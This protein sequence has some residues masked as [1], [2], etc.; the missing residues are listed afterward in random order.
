MSTPLRDSRPSGRELSRIP[1]LDGIRAIAIIAVLFVHGF[2]NAEL[3]PLAPALHGLGRIGYAIASHG[4]LGVDL[5]F[6]LSGFLITGIL[7]DS[8]RRHTYFRDF[9]VRRALRILPLV[10]AVVAILSVIYRPEA[11]YVLMALFFAVDF[12]PL[13]HYGNNGMGPLWSLAVEEQ[14]YLFWPFLVF[15]LRERALMFVTVAVIAIEPVV[16]FLTM[17]SGLLDVLWCRIDGLA[18]GAF[19]AVYV[20]TP[21]FSRRAL[22]AGAGV[23]VAAAVA[24][25][26]V[27]LHSRGASYAL[28]ITEADLIFGAMIAAALALRGHPAFAVLRSAPARFVADTSFCVY[29]IHVPLLDLA[30]LLGIGGTGNAWSDAALRFAFAIPLTFAIAAASRKYFELPFLRLKDTYAPAAP[31]VVPETA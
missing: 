18:I 26:S 11:G 25:F 14:F 24:L 15:F 5:F 4:W 30:R 22:L 1:E 17:G 16:R 8:R 9:W 6:V 28:Q 2:A 21:A 19:I 31:K 12:A 29:L 27:G 7:L 13:L 10:I 20:R 23:A 3:Q